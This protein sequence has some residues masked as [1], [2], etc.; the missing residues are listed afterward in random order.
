MDR[1]F[2][3][4]WFVCICLLGVGRSVKVF[5]D[6]FVFFLVVFAIWMFFVEYF[7]VD[8]RGFVGFEV[9]FFGIYFF[10]R[11]MQ[12]FVLGIRLRGVEGGCSYFVYVSGFFVQ[13]RDWVGQCGVLRLVR[14]VFDFRQLRVCFVYEK[15]RFGVDRRFSGWVR[16][17]RGVWFFSGELDG[18]QTLQESF[19]GSFVL[20]IFFCIEVQNG[21]VIRL[22]YY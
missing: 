17:S 10:S 18:R 14:R 4:C 7:G 20:G 11:R 15:L 1:G 19:Q 13:R 22:F 12:I 5:Q 21:A 2:G 16:K 9:V 6:E 3:G 8:R